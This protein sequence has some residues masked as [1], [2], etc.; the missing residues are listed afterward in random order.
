MAS[1]KENALV[2]YLIDSKA[3]LK[4]VTWPTRKETINATIVVVAVSVGTALFL[5]LLDYG[6]STGLQYLVK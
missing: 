2:R 4:K 5:S 1:W 6:L 3:E